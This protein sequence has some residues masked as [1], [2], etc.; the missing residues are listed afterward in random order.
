MQTSLPNF[1]IVGAAKSGTTAIASFLSQHPDIYICP[2]KEPKFISSHFL[3]FPL[4]GRGDEFIE[5]FTVKSYE[6]YRALFRRVRGQKAI[7]EASVENLY[8]YKQ[9]IP[10]IRHY[11]GEPRIIIVLRD[12][13]NRAF[14]AYKQLLRDRREFLSFE[15]GLGAEGQRCQQNWEFLWHYTAAGFYSCQIGAYLGAF[16]RV[17][18]VLFDDF[19]NDARAFMKDIFEF[20]E[21]DATFEPKVDIR[22]NRS[23]VVR[24]GVWDLLFRVRGQMGTLYK[25]LTLQGFSDSRILYLIERVRHRNMVQ[26]SMHAQTE[27]RLRAL[28]HEDIVRTQQL[29]GRDLRGWLENPVPVQSGVQGLSPQL[30]L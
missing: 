16:Q 19:R 17:K 15:E 1:L 6:Q 25:F 11:L 13:V 12:P 20:L 2:L 5:S 7:G 14:S 27:K 22:L 3:T 24:G 21:V 9:A 23:G 29:I 28:F 26:M 8:Y 4:R 10:W 18:V 30:T